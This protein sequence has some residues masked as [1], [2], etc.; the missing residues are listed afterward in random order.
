M[1]KPLPTYKGDDSY[2]FVCYA[3]ADQGVVKAEI[4]WLQDQGINVWY[5]EGISA[6]KAVLQSGSPRLK[7]RLL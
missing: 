1:D 7:N 2:V 4:R 3:H 5:D 6:G